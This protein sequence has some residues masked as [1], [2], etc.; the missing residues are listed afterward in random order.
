MPCFTCLQKSSGILYCACEPILTRNRKYKI[1]RLKDE[2][3][4]SIWHIG[5]AA[6]SASFLLVL[7]LLIPWTYYYKNVLYWEENSGAAMV[8]SVIALFNCLSLV[9]RVRIIE[10]ESADWKNLGEYHVT[11]AYSSLANILFWTGLAMWF[12]CKEFHLSKL[13]CF[14]IAEVGALLHCYLHY[15]RW[16]QINSGTTKILLAVYILAFVGLGWAFF[17]S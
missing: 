8:L 17:T 2:K 13:F 15:M 16:K 3:N 11:M 5:L 7:I 10:E 9:F 14:L 1:R 12:V 6:V 4:K